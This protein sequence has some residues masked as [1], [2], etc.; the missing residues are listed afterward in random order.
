MKDFSE[1]ELDASKDKTRDIL[2]DSNHVLAQ[3]I[4]DIGESV[5]TLKEDMKEVK[6]SIIGDPQYQVVGLI[7]QIKLF[8][9]R[10]SRAEARSKENVADAVEMMEEKYEKL[11]TRTVNLENAKI[12]ALGAYSATSIGVIAAWEAFKA[13]FHK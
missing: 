1:E 12:W 10:M 5:K 2:R 3:S 13:F 8:E 9:E 7:G 11:A 6:R 4:V